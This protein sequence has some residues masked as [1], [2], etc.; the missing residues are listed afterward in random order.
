MMRSKETRQTCVLTDEAETLFAATLQRLGL[1]GRGYTQIL[2]V[3]RT[4]ADM[5]DSE[6][7]EQ[8]HIAEAVQFRCLDRQYLG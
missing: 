7:I 4:I 6:M 2:K 3:S 5:S 1:S 8:E